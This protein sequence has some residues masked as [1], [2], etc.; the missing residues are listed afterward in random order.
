MLRVTHAPDG[1]AVVLP[2][3]ARA[4]CAWLLGAGAVHTTAAEV[5][6]PPLGA[7]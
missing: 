2:A 6:L 1:G 3:A 4:A 5:R 7:G